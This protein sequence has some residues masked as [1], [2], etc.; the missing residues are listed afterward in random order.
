MDNVYVTGYT[1]SGNFPTTNPSGLYYEPLY[2]T[3]NAYIW[4]FD[5]WQG[6]I[7]GTC[8]GGES[9]DRG[10]SLHIF[11]DQNTPACY[12]YLA[13]STMSDANPGTTHKFPIVATG[14]FASGYQQTSG[15]NGNNY[16]T[17]TTPDG[18]IAAFDLAAAL[19]GISNT[20]DTTGEFSIFPT[21]NAG[22]FGIEVPLSGQQDFVIVV[23]DLLG[24]VVYTESIQSASGTYRKQIVLE[25]VA[26]GA[27]VVQI[28]FE[29]HVATKK[30]IIQK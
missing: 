14:A 15:L 6:P 30:T 25:G 10:Y 22:S 4:G 19:T 28:Q 17:T 13:G 9:F 23:Y 1:R 27:Y 18:F 11:K 3:A 12:M 26:N 20:A 8:F 21:P 5:R 2:G 16:A 7:W 24:Q 29:D